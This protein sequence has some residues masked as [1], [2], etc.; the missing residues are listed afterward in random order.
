MKREAGESRT[1]GWW[2]GRETAGGPESCREGVRRMWTIC[3]WTVCHTASIRGEL[4]RTVTRCQLSQ[5]QT[6]FT[7]SS[8][9]TVQPH[10]PD[11]SSLCKSFFSYCQRMES[12]VQTNSPLILLTSI[13]FLAKAWHYPDNQTESPFCFTLF[14]WHLCE[15]GFVL[16]C[17]N[18]SASEICLMLTAFSVVMEAALAVARTN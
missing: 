2:Q 18:L 4:T 15:G 11:S 6:H 14:T 16:F 1:E 12:K 13:A 5:K 10:R 9:W 3:D 7:A 17:P 8:R